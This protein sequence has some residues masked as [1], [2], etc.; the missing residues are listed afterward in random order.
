[1]G[2]TLLLELPALL[3]KF[4]Y[5]ALTFGTDLHS[6]PNKEREFDCLAS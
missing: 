1:V 6:Y 2:L 3:L 5:N 4:L